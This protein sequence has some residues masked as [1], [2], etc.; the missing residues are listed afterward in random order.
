MASGDMIESCKMRKSRCPD[1]N[2]VRALTSI[3]DHIH[4]HLSLRSLDRRVG[5]TRGHS[6]SLGE[7][8]EVVDQGLHV[9]LHGSTGRRGDLVVLDLQRTRGHLVEALV[10]D[11]ERLTELLQAAQ[12]SVIAVAVDTDGNIELDLVVR[13]IW[14]ALPH[15][16]GDTRAPKH[17]AGEGE[18]QGLSSRDNAN[19]L[20]PVD[21]DTVIGKHLFRFVNP[22]AELSSPLIDIIKQADGNVL[23][24]TT[25]A[26]IGGMESGTGDALIEFLNEY[27]ILAMH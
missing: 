19:A 18:V 14:G 12:V 1:V 15:I 27:Q 13:I 3:A 23:A 2:A 26:D 25:R 10:D 8:Q 24:D 5:V 20:K 9:L 21:P 16:P 22:V 4:A 7:Q 17:D 6:V 11:P